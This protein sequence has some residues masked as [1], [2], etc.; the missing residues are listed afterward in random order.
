MKRSILAVL[1]AVLVLTAGSAQIPQ[2]TISFTFLGVRFDN[3]TGSSNLSSIDMQLLESKI[4]TDLLEIAR[5]EKYALN[6]PMVPGAIHEAL[7]SGST[8]NFRGAMDTLQLD[9]STSGFIWSGITVYP[10]AIH[11][12][13]RLYASPGLELVMHHEYDA[14]DVSELLAGLSTPVYDVFGLAAPGQALAAAPDSRTTPGPSVGAYLRDKD[15]KLSDIAGVWQGDYDL[16]RVLVLGDG[17]AKAF[18]ND[19]DYL[20]LKV[21]ISGQTVRFVQDEPNSPKLYL[22]AFPSYSVASQIVRLARP[23]SWEFM[24]S[25]ERNRLIGKKNTSFFYIEQGVVVQVDNTY[26]RDAEWIRIE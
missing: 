16:A 17:T 23:M 21:S 12:Q 25:I 13:I 1:V 18:F 5:R 11:F 20:K 22:N 15:F 10:D 14:R 26:S 6:F 24:L 2:N 8:D 7:A 4:K 9:F 3:R 19:K